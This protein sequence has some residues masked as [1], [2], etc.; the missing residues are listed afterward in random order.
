MKLNEAL[1]LLCKAVEGTAI[2][3]NV[4]KDDVQIHWFG[5]TEIT[6]SAAT[7]AR[8]ILALKQLEQFGMKDC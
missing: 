3:V 4:D 2:A 8:V 5:V 7:A 1:T 6:C